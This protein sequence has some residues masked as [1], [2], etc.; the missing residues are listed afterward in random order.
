MNWYLYFIFKKATFWCMLEPQLAKNQTLKILPSHTFRK[1][2]PSKYCKHPT[3]SKPLVVSKCPQ[4]CYAGIFL[5]AFLAV[6]WSF[7][8]QTRQIFK[9]VKPGE[10][11]VFLESRCLW[12][13][14]V[15]TG[16]VY[17]AY[18]TIVHQREQLNSF[19]WFHAK[20]SRATSKFIG[21]WMWK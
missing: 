17:T 1:H 2:H 16:R 3:C 21:W 14:V 11:C 8:K 15:T 20:L 18:C 5:V 9:V 4:P 19:S 13:G 12:V 7:N 6:L 10:N